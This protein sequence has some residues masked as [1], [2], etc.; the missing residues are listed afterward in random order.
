MNRSDR[1]TAAGVFVVRDPQV[2]AALETMLAPHRTDTTSAGG[3]EIMVRARTYLAEKMETSPGPDTT[4]EEILDLAYAA[5]DRE[6]QDR[7][8]AAETA[9]AHAEHELDQTRQQLQDAI[10]KIAELEAR[11]AGRRPTVSAQR[12]KD[13]AAFADLADRM[14]RQALTQPKMRAA[15]LRVA[16]QGVRDEI[17]AVYGNTERKAS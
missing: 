6:T 14:D 1:P 5:A 7:I 13:Q 12:A 10:A 17:A 3:D 9:T 8:R 4:I 16:S 15:V 2:C 11:P